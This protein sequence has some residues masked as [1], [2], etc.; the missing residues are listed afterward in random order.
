MAVTRHLSSRAL[1]AYLQ[2]FDPSSEVHLV[3]D[4]SEGLY[5]LEFP[6]AG[7]LLV[8]AAGG[9]NALLLVFSTSGTIAGVEAVEVKGGHF[10]A[11]TGAPV[12]APVLATPVQV[13]TFESPKALEDY[14]KTI[15]A[16]ATVNVYADESAAEAAQSLGNS[17]RYV[18]SFGR[19][20]WIRGTALGAVLFALDKGGKYTIIRK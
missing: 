3:D 5:L 17:F 2:G 10:I 6:P 19:I 7:K 16:G 14:L 9:G 18:C 15:D 13:L 12:A 20:T 4:L 8:V 11:V 1:E